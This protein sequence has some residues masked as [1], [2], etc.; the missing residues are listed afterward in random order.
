MITHKI[1]PATNMYLYA[2]VAINNDHKKYPFCGL[3]SQLVY[4]VPYRNIALVVS[5]VSQKTIRPE[6]NN[7]AVHHEVLKQ[8]MRYNIALLPMRFGNIAKDLNEVHKLLAYHYTTLEEKLKKLTGKVEM[9]VYVTWDVPNI[10]EYF[11]ELY[12]ELK[13]ARDSL[14]LNKRKPSRETQIE[15]GELFYRI[16]DTERGI[17][18]QKMES[19]LSSACEEIVC[20]SSHN[21]KEVMN[22]V[23]LIHYMGR[24]CFEAK[25]EEAAKQWDDH[26]LIKYTGPWPPHHFARLNLEL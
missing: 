22:L 10:Y 20:N 18:I 21:E 25:I 19:L 3:Q 12:P 16:L 26:F 23:C 4:I 13:E 14:L 8:L 24:A 9:G 2:V 7:L 15:V 11:I 1:S 6:R 17:H 5:D